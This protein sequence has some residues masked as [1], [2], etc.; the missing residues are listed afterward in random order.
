MGSLAASNYDFPTL[1]NGTLTVNKAHLTV[2]VSNFSRRANTPNPTLT[3][4]ISGF[5]NGDTVGVVSG[6]PTLSTTATTGSSAGS[7]AI[8]VGIGTL[9]AAN[10]DFLNLVNGILTVTAAVL[11]I[12]DY[13]GAGNSDPA[14]FRRT[15]AATAQ[16]FVDGSSMING[17]TFGSGSLDVPLAADFT[18]TARPTSR[19]IGRVRDSGLWKSPPRITPDNFLTTFGGPNDIPVPANYNGT[20]KAVVAVYR[21]TT[22]QW[23]FQ[24]QSQPLTFTTYKSGDIPIPGNYDNTGK[25]EP[26]IYRPSAGQWI[27]DSPKGVHHHL[28]WWIDRYS[29]SRHYYA[30]TSVTRRSNRPSGVRAPASS[31]F[32]APTGGTRTLQFAVGDIPAPAIMTA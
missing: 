11:P 15:T 1:V 19:S 22:G 20:G 4:T 9:S 5:V 23:F 30:L 25:D 24:G 14:V 31:S 2:T 32:D 26:A 27:I 12:N 17:R 21:P 7:Y 3:T 6:V 16:W 10:Y 8:N 13:T 18:A 28:F 29:C